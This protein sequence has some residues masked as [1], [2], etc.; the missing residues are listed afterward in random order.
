MRIIIDVN[1][2][3]H[4]HLFKNFVFI[5][6][7]KGWKVLF[8]AKDKEVTLDLLKAYNLKYKNLGGHYSGTLGKIYSL[9]LHVW[10]LF[11]ISVKFKPDMY[12]SH[13]SVPASWV[14]FLLG[15][16]YIAFEDTGN[17]EQIR[18]YKPFADAILTTKSFKKDF[19]KIHVRYNGYHE[20]AYLHPNY[21]TAN[22]EIFNFLNINKNE[23]Y[24]ILRFVSWGASHDVGQGG[25]SLENKRSIV[26]ILQKHGK[27]FI[28]SEAGLPDDLKPLQIKIP[29]EKMH[30]ALAYAQ[31]FVGEGATMASECAVLGTPAIYINTMIAETITEQQNYGLLFH[32]TSPECIINKIT[33]LLNIKDLK[34]V[35]AERRNKMLTEKIDVTAFLTDFVERFPESLQRAKS[36][37]NV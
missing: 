20:I 7:S 27:V 23:T 8:T 2:P 31:M 28:S 24:F 34:Q 12:L 29:P 22:P 11:F 14:S 13:G 16:K 32:F 36:L 21:F 17:M 35:W 18:L 5:A 30:D 33:E 15:K 6:Q 25:L 4:V 37:Q 3:G 19:G 10:R 26:N 9:L 1:H